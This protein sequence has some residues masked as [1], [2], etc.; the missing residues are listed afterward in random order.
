[1][2][3]PG[4]MF[5]VGASLAAA[6]IKEMLGEWRVYVVSFIRLLLIP[7]MAFFILKNLIPERE[8]LLPLVLLLGMPTASVAT[9]ISMECNGNTALVSKGVCAT[10]IFSMGTLPLIALIANL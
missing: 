8:M 1:M 5:V 9:M 6:S 4:A 3:T 10:A 2:T 7:I